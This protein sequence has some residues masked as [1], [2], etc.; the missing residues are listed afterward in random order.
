MIIL[1]TMQI[2]DAKITIADGTAAG[3]QVQALYH[4]A[5]VAERGGDLAKADAFYD[6][7]EEA[8]RLQHGAKAAP[9]QQLLRVRMGVVNLLAEQGHSQPAE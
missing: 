4:L 6:D 7:V 9:D 1:R 8:W 3:G 5:V 2:V